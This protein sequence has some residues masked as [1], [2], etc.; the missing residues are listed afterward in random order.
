MSDEFSCDNGR[1]I[2]DELSCNGYNNCGD[3]S[4]ATCALPTVPM[5]VIIGG[6]IFGF[7][8]LTS[9]V[10][11]IARNRRRSRIYLA[12]SK[13]LLVNTEMFKRPYVLYMKIYLFR[14]TRLKDSV[15]GCGQLMSS[16]IPVECVLIGPDVIG[17]FHSA[18]KT[19]S[20]AIKNGGMAKM[21]VVVCHCQGGELFVRH[22]TLT[23]FLDTGS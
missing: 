19:L 17:L 5:A 8:I 3:W 21:Y 12:V 13:G 7:I 10:I 4:D 22:T 9:I 15:V 23:V 2:D 1:C 6:S 18:F 20:F 11:I 16:P 14:D